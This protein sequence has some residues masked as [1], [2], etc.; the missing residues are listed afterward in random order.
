[1]AREKDEEK[2]KEEGEVQE[3]KK[4]FPSLLII[5]AV[6]V[7]L[8]LG[9]AGA[10]YFLFF[11][12]GRVKEGEGH[13]GKAQ[14]T[15]AAQES[16]A[17]VG[18]MKNLDPFI[19]NLTDAQGTRYLKVVVQLELK[20]ELVAQEIDKKTPMIRDEIISL[21]SS[22]SF[23]EIAT[24]PG[25]RDLKQVMLERINKYLKTGQVTRIYFTD[26]VVQ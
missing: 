10:A 5:L 2:E 20:S 25:K 16:A 21:L 1:M 15:Q 24:E 8:I 3:K 13:G 26:F 7:V 23:D 11:A 6:V 12:K 19:V 22:K 18:A 14:Q 9:G 4:K 17:A